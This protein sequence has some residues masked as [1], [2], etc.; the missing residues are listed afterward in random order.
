MAIRKPVTVRVYCVSND[1]MPHVERVAS[2]ARAILSLERPEGQTNWTGE[3]RLT[4]R[5][6]EMPATF[7]ARVEHVRALLNRA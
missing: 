1:E 2:L 3:L 5:L 4:P 7:N 6:L